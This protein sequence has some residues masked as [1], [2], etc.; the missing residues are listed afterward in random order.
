MSIFENDFIMRQ[1]ED[2][3]GMIGKVFLHRQ[4]SKEVQEEELSDEKAKNYLRKLRKLID[5]GKYK[6]AVTLIKDDFEDGNMEF[7]SVALSCFDQ[8]NA[9]TESELTNSGYSRN[10]LYNDLSFI[11]DQFGIQL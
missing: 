7:L 9:R 2:I 3:T 5:E 11:T 1:I 10:Q 8:I 4:A 6:E